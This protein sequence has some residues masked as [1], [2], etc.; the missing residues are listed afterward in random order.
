VLRVRSKQLIGSVSKGRPK[1]KQA[2]PSIRQTMEAINLLG[3]VLVEAAR[4]M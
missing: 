4:R 1:S 2:C 3:E